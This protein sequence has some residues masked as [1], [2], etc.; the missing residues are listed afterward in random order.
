VVVKSTVANALLTQNL[1]CCT[2]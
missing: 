2:A 1:L